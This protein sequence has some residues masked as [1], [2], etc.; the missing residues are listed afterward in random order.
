M[1]PGSLALPAAET[2]N[3]LFPAGTYL[4]A[5]KFDESSGTTITDDS[6]NSRPFTLTSDVIRTS[7]GKIDKGLE[8][9]GTNYA[10]RS[11]A[12]I[13]S[14]SSN[15]FGF[16]AWVYPVSPASDIYIYSLNYRTSA[17]ASENNGL[18]WVINSSSQ[19]FFRIQQ[20]TRS[21]YNGGIRGEWVTGL[22]PVNNEWNLVVCN[23][24]ASGATATIWN[25]TNGRTDATVSASLSTL[26]D[27]PSDN[28][29]Y[30][31]AVRPGITGSPLVSG[32][33]N[34]LD[35]IALRYAEFSNQDIIDLWNSGAGNQ[36]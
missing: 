3:G 29:N 5:Y 6:G 13:L 20:N 17:T 35:M 15:T 24:N 28:I 16:C 11:G 21:G 14:F 7:A 18:R 25:A 32:S 33:G 12:N 36:I 2:A 8:S 34:K 10:S 26:N 1:I 19:L 9:D 30:I 31:N 23:R 27:F 22:S 4:A